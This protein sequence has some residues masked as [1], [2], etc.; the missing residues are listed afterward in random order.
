MIHLQ[1]FDAMNPNQRPI[2]LG[3]E[4]NQSLFD[5]HHYLQKQLNVMGHDRV[6]LYLCQIFCPSLDVEIGSLF[7]VY[8][9]NVSYLVLFSKWST[10]F[11]IFDH[12]MLGIIWKRCVATTEYS[13]NKEHNQ[14]D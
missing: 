9:V 8:E 1:L 6:N 3:L 2:R 4:R 10:I 11:G 13:Q 14:R 5:I 12:T 7:D